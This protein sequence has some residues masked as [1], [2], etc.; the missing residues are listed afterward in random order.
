MRDIGKNVKGGMSNM[1]ALMALAQ[2]AEQER[3]LALEDHLESENLFGA[4]KEMQKFNNLAKD[5]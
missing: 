5:Y 2:Q 4:G 3:L 1:L